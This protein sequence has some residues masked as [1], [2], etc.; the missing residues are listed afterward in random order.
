MKRKI[1]K[2]SCVIMTVVLCFITQ[3]SFSQNDQNI[4]TL[5]SEIA[6]FKKELK[7][8]EKAG[9]EILPQDQWHSYF[10]RYFTNRYGY[11]NKGEDMQQI[12]D[13]VK[14]E[15]KQ[16]Y[17]LGVAPS[18]SK[19]EEVDIPVNFVLSAS[20]P[21]FKILCLIFNDHEEA[22]KYQSDLEKIHGFIYS[23]KGYKQPNDYFIRENKAYFVITHS[24]SL[25]GEIEK[26]IECLE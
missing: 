26:V 16:D 13:T 25:S 9:Y 4:D 19:P 17:L 21:S 24:S 12:D 23:S 14:V 3:L 15:R 20:V 10:H 8:L 18:G 6:L 11:V 5:R 22:I 2:T 1:W 7:K